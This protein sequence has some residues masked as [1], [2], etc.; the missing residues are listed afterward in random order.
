MQAIVEGVF[1]EIRG[2]ERIP[3]LSMSKKVPI[4]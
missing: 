1:Y 2:M 4:D 3:E